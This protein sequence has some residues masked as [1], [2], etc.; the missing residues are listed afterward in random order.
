MK[1]IDKSNEEALRRVLLFA[2]WSYLLFVV[3][4]S[5]VPLEFQ[6]RPITEAWQAFLRIPH[7]AMDF[8]PSTDRDANILLYIPLGFL[9]AGW[10][11]TIRGAGLLNGLAALLACAAVSAGVEF[12]QLFFPLRTSSINDI[13]ANTLGGAAGVALWQFFGA[14]FMVLLAEMR[15]GGPHAVRAAV[16]LYVAAYL[17]FSLF[18]Y[19]FRISPQE[20]AQKLGSGQFH[21]LIA[22]SP[23]ASPLL[24][25]VKLA[26]EVAAVAPLGI[27]MGMAARGAGR[28]AYARSWVYGLLLGL[29]IEGGQFF[30]ASGISQGI[31]VFTRGAGMALGLA[32]FVRVKG[33]RL[34]RLR[35]YLGRA[36]MLGG[37]LYLALLAALNGWFAPHWLGWSAGLQ[38]LTELHFV[39]FYYHYFTT[40]TAALFSVLAYAGMYAP[41]GLGTWAWMAARNNARKTSALFAGLL[42]GGAAFVLEAGKLFIADKRPDPTDLLIAVAA[43]ATAFALAGLFSRWISEV[44]VPAAAPTA[45]AP[46]AT[47]LG[48]R[49]LSSILG[50][51]I[52]WAIFDYPLGPYWLGLGLAVYVLL[53]RRFPHFWLIAIPASMPVLDFSPWTGRIFLGELDLLVLATVAVGLWRAPAMA[54]RPAFTP[55]TRLLVGLLA[56][57]YLVSLLVGLLPLQP[58]DDN[59]F[60]SYLSHYDS[61]RAAK[62]FFLALLLLPLLQD[63]A[64]DPAV[65]WRNWVSAGLALGAALLA[66]AVLWERWLFPGLLD[67]S[68][69]YR[70][71]A[72]FAD[73]QT[74]GPQVETYA[75]LT[76]PFV[77]TWF[78]ARPGKLSLAVALPVFAAAVHAVLVTFARGGYLALVVV[79]L[80]LAAGMVPRRGA[81]RRPAA[82]RRLF[83]PALVLLAVAV[84]VPVASGTFIQSRFAQTGID[85]GIR[86]VHW[87]TALGMIG[88]DGFS[89]IFGMGLGSFP[90][91]Y[92]L[93]NPQGIRPGNYRFERENGNA[94]LRLHP[95]D[96]YYV[97]QKVAVAAG[98]NYRLSLDLRSAAPAGAKLP[99]AL[100][101]KHVL[102]SFRCKALQFASTPGR[103]GW[104]H[105]ELAFDSG[106]TGRGNPLARRAVQLAFVGPG[107]AADVDN[108]RLIGPDGADLVANGDFSRGADRWFFTTDDGWPWRVENLGLQFLFEQGWLGLILFAMLI[109]RQLY[110]L[111]GP[112]L[113]GDAFAVGLL[114]SFSGLLTVGLFGSV[115]ESPRLAMLFFLLVFAAELN[116]KLAK[117]ARSVGQAAPARSAPAASGSRAARTGE[118]A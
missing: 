104:E 17:A 65:R 37:P 66:A 21:F 5:L 92:Y 15:S 60:S 18:P 50:A 62:G 109:A 114:A 100:C 88:A 58:L 79:L 61:L 4:G 54:E 36:A 99:I 24:C 116:V 22:G 97:G 2:A 40:E 27:L 3:Y 73:M 19:D 43:A 32:L 55:A 56:L 111:A 67:F 53:L 86:L 49:L 69:E 39:P 9:A 12:A 103:S 113:R 44:P 1:I 71:T 74:G 68:A 102:Y 31:S 20:L 83:P 6:A 80:V 57:S 94:F 28:P 112:A 87:K 77:A 23:C 35:P 95:G 26:A 115:F 42:A 25:I 85:L 101:E 41:F 52:G 16:V 89:K 45:E 96:A 107:V 90:A 33:H 118:K 38:R 70:V 46:P 51:L 10:L 7:Q 91:T 106:E 29:L 30:L 75:V 34:G 72:F 14:R 47:I 13:I 108:V 82:W 98:A 63:C 110:R 76:L 64:G 117:Q 105:R 84:A 59:A 8:S 93:E 81:K 48:A 11:G 78:L